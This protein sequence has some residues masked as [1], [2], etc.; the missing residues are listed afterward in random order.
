MPL[1]CWLLGSVAAAGHWTYH[2]TKTG[3]TNW[4][5]LNSSYAACQGSRQSPIDVTPTSTVQTRSLRL[6]Y[7][8]A[9]P[10]V[11]EEKHAS[12]AYRFAD[13]VGTA[14]LDGTLSGD[15]KV[16]TL[17][18]MHLHTPA[19]H[20]LNG[21]RHSLEI[22][23]VHVAGDKALLALAVLAQ[24]GPSTS[25]LILPFL[26]SRLLDPNSDFTTTVD[27]ASLANSV[28]T[29][30]RI[31][32]YNGSLTI[33]PCNPVTWT[34]STDILTITESDL[35]RLWTNQPLANARP[36][37]FHQSILFQ[38]S[39]QNVF[40]SGLKSSSKQHLV[41]IVVVNVALLSIVAF[42]N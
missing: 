10:A 16:Y 15:H 23:L 30:G 29:L 19:E 11:H 26:D 1:F 37:Q 31:V 28:N 9:V 27:L 32:T 40:S 39:S 2:E 24:I 17:K 41:W 3:P 5:M 25:T 38:A 8:S 35:D 42:Y 20:H 13:S 4:H 7:A 14:S 34:I 33:P 22:H 12:L 36:L 21:V 18:G 6:L